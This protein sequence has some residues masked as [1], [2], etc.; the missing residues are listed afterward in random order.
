[1]RAG[2]KSPAWSPGWCSSARQVPPELCSL[3]QIHAGAIFGSPLPQ[4]QRDPDRGVTPDL[5]SRGAFRTSGAQGQKRPFDEQ[6]LVVG[7]GC[8]RRSRTNTPGTVPGWH[9]THHFPSLFDQGE[10]AQDVGLLRSPAHPACGPGTLSSLPSSQPQT[11][12]DIWA[13][14]E[15]PAKTTDTHTPHKNN[16]V[17]C[18]H[19]YVVTT[20]DQR[21]QKET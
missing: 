7:V 20:E 2:N 6:R 10:H 16:K 15:N 13:E 5:P 17:N 21:K 9:D 12:P 14:M 4:Q 11:R 1:M 8:R 19:M 18:V 3:T